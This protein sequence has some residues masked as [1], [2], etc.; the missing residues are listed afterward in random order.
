MT[1]ITKPTAAETP[2]MIHFYAQITVVTDTHGFGQVMTYGDELRLS[3]TFRADNT[4]RVGYC[5]LDLLDDEPAQVRR[6]GRVVF[7]SGPWPDGEPRIERG[8]PEW[9]GAH[10]VARREA[11]KIENEGELRQRL[12]EIE[13]EFVPPLVMNHTLAQ[14]VGDRRA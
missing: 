10:D 1:K 6:W 14:Y 2:T 9:E 3:G 12:R 8:T 4:D 5:F 11:W 7:R 13:A